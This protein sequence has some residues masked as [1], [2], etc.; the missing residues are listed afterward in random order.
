LNKLTHHLYVFFS[1]K[2]PWFVP[3]T[4]K[5]KHQK[6]MAQRYARCPEP[7]LTVED[8]S[9]IFMGTGLGWPCVLDLNI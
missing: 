2:S 6:P 3:G 9:Q 5:K 1:S 8:F 7:V 4:V